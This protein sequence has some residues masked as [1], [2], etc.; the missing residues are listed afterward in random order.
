MASWHEWRFVYEDPFT[1]SMLM[2]L[3]HNFTWAPKCIYEVCRWTESR[4]NELYICQTDRHSC[5]NQSSCNLCMYKEFRRS[6][7]NSKYATRIFKFS[8]TRLKK[9]HIGIIFASAIE[10]FILDILC[11]Y[12]FPSAKFEEKMF[13]KYCKT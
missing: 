4:T 5:S 11:I 6:T 3:W 12:K 13:Q 1:R 9:W 2:G 10:Y 8:Q 7:G